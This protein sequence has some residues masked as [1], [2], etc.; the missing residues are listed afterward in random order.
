MIWG[1]SPAYGKEF[2]LRQNVGM[3]LGT[4][5]FPVQWV[6]GAKWPGCEVDHLPPSS[7]EVK[8][9][10]SC[11]SPPVICLWLHGMNRNKLIFYK[12]VTEKSHQA[13]SVA[14]VVFPVMQQDKHWL[15][16]RSLSREKMHSC[17]ETDTLNS[18]KVLH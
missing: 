7:A 17:T 11:T 1:L 5:R 14:R 2:S 3:S 4:V 15:L 16:C 8:N 6:L 9:E 18:L 12:I 10:W 13:R